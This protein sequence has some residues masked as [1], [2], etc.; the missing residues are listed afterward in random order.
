MKQLHST[1]VC[2]HNLTKSCFFRI[3]LK[4][5]SLKLHIYFTICNTKYIMKETKCNLGYM[6]YKHNEEMV[7]DY[8]QQAK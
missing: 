6:F 4:P 2:K 1:D 7:L 3:H 5:I 8:N